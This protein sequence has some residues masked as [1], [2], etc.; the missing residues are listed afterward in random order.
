MSFCSEPDKESPGKPTY[1]RTRTYTDSVIVSWQPP[2][3]D[4]I[5]RGYICGYGEGVP[6]VNWKY[7]DASMS[8]VT[9][10]NLSEQLRITIFHRYVMLSLRT[11]DAV[12]R[13]PAGV[14][15]LW[16]RARCV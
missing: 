3:E 8:N 1:V 9:I 13:Q 10:T 12:R 2:E 4:T 7:V 5:V 6:D 14:Q 16:Q 11:F 15:Q